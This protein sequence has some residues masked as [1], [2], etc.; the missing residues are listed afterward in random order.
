MNE[1]DFITKLTDDEVKQLSSI[2]Q[3][4]ISLRIDNEALR[5]H[6]WE[7]VKAVGRLLDDKYTEGDSLVRQELWTAMHRTGDKA[8]EFLQSK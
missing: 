4:K 5:K 1:L 6:L 7:L 2:L 8:R 3:D